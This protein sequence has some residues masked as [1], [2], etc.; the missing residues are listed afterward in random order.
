MVILDTNAISEALSQRPNTIVKAWLVEQPIASIFTTAVTEAE[1]LRGLRAL[2]DGKRKRD[3][4]AAVRP[5]FENESQPG[6]R[7]ELLPL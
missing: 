7:R 3:L 5:I 1:I 4:E 6:P 2:P